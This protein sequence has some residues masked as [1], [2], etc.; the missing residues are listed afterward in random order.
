[1]RFNILTF[2][3]SQNKEFIEVITSFFPHSATRDCVNKE[4]G[5]D[6]V[7]GEWG[8]GETRQEYKILP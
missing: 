5:D 6:I 1:M 4:P 7:R 2:F 8:W 3:V